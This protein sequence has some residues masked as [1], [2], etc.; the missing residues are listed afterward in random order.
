MN[1]RMPFLREI[2][3]RMGC[4]PASA[5]SI[6]HAL[7]PGNVVILVVGGA[8]EALDTKPGQ[9]VLTLARRKGFYRLALQHGADLVPSFGFGENDIFETMEPRSFFRMLQLRAYKMMSFS[10]PIF[11]GR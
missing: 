9:Y 10:M 4:I 2:V 3:S 11:Y 5:G 6:H 8:A 7:K 1:F